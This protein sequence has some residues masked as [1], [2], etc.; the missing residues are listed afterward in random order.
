MK[1]STASSLLL[2][3]SIVTVNAFGRSS[4]DTKGS[5]GTLSFPQNNNDKFAVL[6]ASS[7]DTATNE[8]K[9]SAS[10]Q[11]S[12]FSSKTLSTKELEQHGLFLDESEIQEATLESLQGHDSFLIE[13]EED[14]IVS[15][16]EAQEVVDFLQGMKSMDSLVQE[17]ET[18]EDSM[19]TLIKEGLVNKAENEI[20]I[21]DTVEDFE[22]SDIFVVDEQYQHVVDDIKNDHHDLTEARQLLSDIVE[23]KKE[24]ASVAVEE[25]KAESTISI[26][27]E[28][29]TNGK[30]KNELPTFFATISAAATAAKERKEDLLS[31]M[32]LE[33][34]S[35]SSSLPPLGKVKSRT[36]F[37]KNMDVSDISQ[38]LLQAVTPDIDPLKKDVTELVWCTATYAVKAALS[39]TKTLAMVTQS[40]MDVAA[41]DEVEEFASR[42]VK[43]AINEKDVRQTVESAGSTIGAMMHCIAAS[44]NTMY[45]LEGIKETSQSIVTTV[46]ALGVLGVKQVFHTKDVLDRAQA[47]RAEKERVQEEQ[48]R[49]QREKREEQERLQEQQRLEA[50]KKEQEEIRVAA[51]RRIDEKRLEA[52]RYVKKQLEIQLEKI[53]HDAQEEKLKL[54]H[55]VPLAFGDTPE[56]KNDDPSLTKTPGTAASTTAEPMFFASVNNNNN[57]SPDTSFGEGN[58]PV[59]EPMFFAKM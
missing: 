28:E 13:M 35:T 55:E 6:S 49:V 38:N 39:T 22:R 57:V 29:T 41:D 53:K 21:E 11:S 51:E 19:T 3:Q 5:R 16:T 18:E 46:A 59:A 47:E 42:T 27:S 23:A 45:A 7:I 26:K 31:K 54:I 1:T 12:K 14:A 50:L 8:E 2:F 24:L 37:W 36:P 30:N 15:N 20:P 43:A 40:I 10:S 4:Y 9:I 34:I 44:R 32:N 25:N 58:A 52:E 17:D 48:E 33:G 56:D